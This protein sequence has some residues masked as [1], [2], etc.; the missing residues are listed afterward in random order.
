LFCNPR[1]DNRDENVRNVEQ[2]TLSNGPELE[3]S[4]ND[5]WTKVVECDSDNDGD[6]DGEVELTVMDTRE[7][8]GMGKSFDRIF[9]VRLLVLCNNQ[10]RKP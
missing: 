7:D 4:R 2:Q 1:V 3:T 9:I 8:G 6:G 5:D 10:K